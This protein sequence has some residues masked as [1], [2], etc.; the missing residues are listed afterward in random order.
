MQFR[1]ALYAVTRVYPQPRLTAFTLAL[2]AVLAVLIVD[3]APVT[4]RWS[5]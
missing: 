4:P 2:V 5:R 1:A 3:T